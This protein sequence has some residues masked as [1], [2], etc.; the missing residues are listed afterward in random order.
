MLRDA[1]PEDATA[2]ADL[3]LEHPLWRMY[4][5]ERDA[6]IAR[7]AGVL[8]N[9]SCLVSEA[10]GRLQGFCVFDAATFGGSGYIQLLGVRWG[11]T[12]RGEGARLLRAVHRRLSAVTGRAFLLCTA[13]NVAAQRFYAQ[14]GYVKVGELP[15]WVRPQIDETIFCNYDITRDV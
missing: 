9:R 15:G 5:L 13:S 14:H 6:E 8:R 12:G 1:V 2:I 11:L 7:L 4:G 10:E 3:M